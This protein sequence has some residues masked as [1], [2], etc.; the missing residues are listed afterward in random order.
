MEFCQFDKWKIFNETVDF[1]K[2]NDYT[3]LYIEKSFFLTSGMILF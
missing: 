1:D 3:I 2:L